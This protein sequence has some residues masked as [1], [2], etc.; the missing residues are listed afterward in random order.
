MSIVLIGG[1]LHGI[2]QDDC[3]EDSL[4][5][6]MEDDDGKRFVVEYKRSVVI[7]DRFIYVKEEE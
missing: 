4:E 1:P 3:L 5:F 2:K 6:N 7:P